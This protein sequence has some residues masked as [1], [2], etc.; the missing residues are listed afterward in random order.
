MTAASL[1]FPSV[2]LMQYVIPADLTIVYFVV[3]LLTGIAFISPIRIRKPGTRGILHLIGIGA[4]E[5]IVMMLLRWL[6]FRR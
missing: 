4:V 6:L 5:F 2:A 1:I 3:A